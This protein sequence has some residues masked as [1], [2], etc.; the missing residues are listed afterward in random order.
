[1]HL[2][3]IAD[4]A[5][6]TAAVI[7]AEVA[8]AGGAPATPLPWLI[9]FPLI[10][11]AF[12]YTRGMYR[13]PPLHVGVL[14]GGRAIVTATSLA[15]AIVISLR[16]VLADSSSVAGKS[17]GMWIL[18]TVLLVAVRTSLVLSESRTRRAGAVCHPTLIVGAGDVGRLAA[19][20][21]RENAELGLR[22]VGFLDDE[23]FDFGDQILELPILGSW[24]DL[25]QIVEEQQIE[26]VVVTFSNAHD[27]VLLQ[28]LKRCE[29]LGVQTSLVPR[30]HE[31]ATEQAGVVRIG[32]LPLVSSCSPKPRGWQFAVKYAFDRGAAALALLLL[33]PVM[34]ALALAIWLSSGRPILY[35]QER[36][37]RDGK[38]FDMLKFRSMRP[39]T[40]QTNVNVSLSADTA[41]G[42]VEGDDRR[43][44]L[45]TF[46]RRTSLDE[47]PQLLNVLRGE[48]SFI[49]PRP[50]RPEFVQ[51]FEQKVHRYADRHRVKSG[52]TGWA[53]VSGL[54]GKTSVADRIEWDNY[55]IENWSLWFDLKILLMT[56]AVV[57]R[58]GAVE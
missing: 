36:V 39:A 11:L 43:T 35:R 47:L 45:G 24:R 52:I 2:R 7:L 56:L 18:A 49:G 55:Y 12:L 57:A 14:D 50:E 54:R 28:V 41:P 26:H 19:S 6:L 27:E 46:M 17:A 31:K 25:E 44:R 8:A 13:P 32:G 4:V 16:V 58:P 15:A 40:N 23:A 9:A 3:L 5:T 1:V 30:L 21:L 10:V 48:M 22:P 42:G 53:Q 38:R 37:G 51:M 29:E 20:R 33:T 34:G